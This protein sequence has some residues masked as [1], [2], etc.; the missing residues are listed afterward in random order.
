MFLIELPAEIGLYM[1]GNHFVLLGIN[2]L[3]NSKCLLFQIN[4]G[5]DSGKT[6]AEYW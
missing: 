2:I 3:Q 4:S 5:N 6:G 1:V